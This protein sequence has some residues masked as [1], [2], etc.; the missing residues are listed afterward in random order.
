MVEIFKGLDKA[1]KIRLILF[2]VLLIWCI[3]LGVG[4]SYEI[5][6]RQSLTGGVSG[7]M[8]HPSQLNGNYM[9]DGSDF[10]PL[11]IL[12]GYGVNG[13]LAIFYIFIILVVVVVETVLIFIP[14]LI[15]RLLGLKEKYEV[16]EEEYKFIKY[17][18]LV[19][20]GI[21]IIAS[22]IITKFIGIIPTIM[23][24]ADW[25][26]IMLIYVLGYKKRLK[27]IGVKE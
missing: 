15:L 1:A 21:C 23:F 7:Q 12:L 9:I 10:T 13:I 4:F 20:L 17:S 22:L 6:G 14:V 27:N 18:Y 2:F 5:D 19:T 3:Y 24:N 26:L 25:A 11:V 8:A 16:S